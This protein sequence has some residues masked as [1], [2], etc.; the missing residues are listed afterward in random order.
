MPWARRRSRANTRDNT[1]TSPCPSA[2]REHRADARK[3][4]GADGVGSGVRRL[5]DELLLHG[6]GR[7]A[8]T[9]AGCA[10]LPPEGRGRAAALSCWGALKFSELKAHTEPVYGDSPI[11]HQAISNAQEIPPRRSQVDCDIPVTA[12]IAWERDG[13]ERIATV[14]Y[15][16]NWELALVRV[17]YAHGSQAVGSCAADSCNDQGWTV[18]SRQSSRQP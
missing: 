5:V 2:P 16:Y 11:P 3:R 18:D 4:L 8:H 13:E 1:A 6:R 15:A 9:P 12:R 7:G 10:R 17:S 14:A